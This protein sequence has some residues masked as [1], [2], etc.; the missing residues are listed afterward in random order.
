MNSALFI[1]Q[2]T[3]ENFEKKIL[4]ERIARLS[5]GIAVIKVSLT[6]MKFN[7]FFMVEVCELVIRLDLKRKLN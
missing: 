5:G 4:N 1:L 7:N 3:E 6:I 2:N